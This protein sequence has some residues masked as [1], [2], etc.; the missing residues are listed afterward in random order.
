[1]AYLTP[2]TIFLNLQTLFNGRVE[3]TFFH[4]VANLQYMKIN[5]VRNVELTA[6]ELSHSYR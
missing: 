4:L 6:L 1:M 5:C 3:S 2:I